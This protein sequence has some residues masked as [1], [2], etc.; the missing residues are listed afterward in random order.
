MQ[1]KNN[2]ILLLF[3]VCVLVISTLVK[4]QSN[5]WKVANGPQ[6]HS[7][8]E[9]I[10]DKTGNLY[11]GT[12]NGTWVSTDNGKEWFKIP[13][14]V[15]SLCFAVDSSNNIYA[16]TN[17]GVYKLS[18]QGK[19]SRFLGLQSNKIQSL[20]IKSDTIMFA[21]TQPY[22][23]R[24]TNLG[25]TWDTVNNNIMEQDDIQTLALTST[26]NILLGNG[27]FGIY[28][29]TNNGNSWKRVLTDIND[30]PNN[31]IVRDSRDHLLCGTYRGIYI[32]QDNGYT[33]KKNDSSLA[34][35][36]VRKIVALKNGLLF[37]SVTNAGVYRSLDGGISWV[38]TSISPVDK[39]ICS[40]LDDELFAVT[41]D[42]FQSKDGGE[43][44]QLLLSIL[45]VNNNRINCIV[46][47]SAN[48]VYLGCSDGCYISTDQGIGWKNILLDSLNESVTAILTD[49]KSG[50]FVGTRNGNVFR[51]DSLGAVCKK[52][53]SPTSDTTL[54]SVYL[55]DNI[56]NAFCNDDQG[57]I[58]ICGI[59]GVFLTTDMGENWVNRSD[60]IKGKVVSD[61]IST[62]NKLI[63]ATTVFGMIGTTGDAVYLS[64]DKGMSWQKT[65]DTLSNAKVSSLLLTSDSVLW[66]GTYENTNGYGK[67]FRTLNW[68]VS[69]Q[70]VEGPG[71]NYYDLISDSRR[72]I[73]IGTNGVYHSTDGGKSW[74]SDTDGTLTQYLDCYTIA[75]DEQGLVYAGRFSVYKT[76][77][78]L[79]TSITNRSFTSP[80]NFTLLQ[81][82]PN[83]FN[84]STTISFNLPKSGKVI[85]TI[86]DCLGR[87]VSTLL[88]EFKSAGYYQI[89]YN[90]T[91]LA[92]GVYFYELKSE[93]Y[94]FVKKMILLK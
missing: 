5:I 17:A 59:K 58:F 30:S 91:S 15:T 88:N 71:L 39:A 47:K 13:L 3:I 23:Y 41:P 64:T 92:S 77:L 14:A 62:K 70:E 52:L 74:E 28:M 9:M 73:Y 29:S 16:G 84:L 60:G 26:G 54:G 49:S 44:W 34:T 12:D 69:W 2:R 66:A 68:G 6:W 31:C 82:Y 33:W 85:L 48:E 11:I 46:S 7:V 24:S 10:A 94:N 18:N 8:G 80:N 1:I 45:N 56:I 50:V 65:Q 87:K 76:M 38:K 40:N 25:L 53:T 36:Y 43:T 93:R 51:I 37:A 4:A 78:P 22:I 32:S 75:V 55:K 27:H 79:V 72:N 86:Y 19:E 21:G 63:C 42:V 90:A 83:P 35:S 61:I 20:L 89:H 81:N 67:L 57:N